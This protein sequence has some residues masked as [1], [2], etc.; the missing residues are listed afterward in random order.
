MILVSH[1]LNMDSD[2]GYCRLLLF[3]RRF[4]LFH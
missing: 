3:K 4:S 2:H 1:G